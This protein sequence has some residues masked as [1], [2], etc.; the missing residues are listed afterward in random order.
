MKLILQRA[1]S[2][3]EATVERHG[4]V[5]RITLDCREH[6]V[7]AAALADGLTSLLVGGDQYEVGVEPIA[8]RGADPGA[9]DRYLVTVAGD[10]AEEVVVLDPLAHLARRTRGGGASA[11]RGPV[12]APMP[13]RVVAVLVEEGTEVAAGQGIVVVEAMKMENEIAAE[14]AG[15]VTRIHVETGQAVEGGDPLFEIG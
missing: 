11:G 7:D 3:V 15:T 10:T 1:G 6:P 8:A 12:A 5:Y 14:R 13:G 4:S 2:D 9:G